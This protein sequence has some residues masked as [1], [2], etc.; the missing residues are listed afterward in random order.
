MKKAKFLLLTLLA[1]LGYSGAWAEYTVD[2][3]STISTS[4]SDFKVASNWKHIVDV[5]TYYDNNMSYQY[6]EDQGMEGSGTL[7]CN[8]Q[9]MYDWGQ[10][11]SGVVSYDLL[12]TPV[13]SGTVTIYAL[14]SSSAS[15][16]AKGFVEFWSLN[17]DGT[18]RDTKLGSQEWTSNS[19]AEWTAVT[20]T[21][22]TP[23]R[24]GIRGQ[25]VYLDNFSASS[26]EIVA[27]TSLTVA[28]VMNSTGQTGSTGT[29]PVFEQQPDGNMIA[30]LKVELLNSGD[31]DLIAGTTEGY[32]LTLGYASTSSS[33]PT[34]FTD[35]DVAITEDL[36]AG[37]TK[38]L[39]VSFNVPF[40]S[41]YKYYFIKENVTGTTTT[42]PRYATSVT[43]EPKFAFREAG[44]TSTSSLSG[45]VDF[46]M[47]STETTKNYE[48][49]NDGTAP[50]IVNSITAPEGFTMNVA[51]TDDTD[52]YLMHAGYDAD[53]AVWYAWTWYEGQDGTWVAE[54]DGKFSGLRDKVL[55]VRMNPTGA[56]SWDNK[57][58]Q[59]VDLDVENGSI[60]VIDGWGDE[61]LEGHWAIRVPAK[62]AKA[63]DITLPVTTTGAFSGNLEVKY[64]NASNTEVTYT[65][66]FTG[67]VL[68]EGVWFCDFN[69]SKTSSS[70]ASY[71]AGSVVESSTLYAAATGSYN[72]Y[73]QY[74][75]SY[76]RHDGNKFITPKLHFEAGETMTFDAIKLQTGSDYNITVYVC[77]DRMEWGSPFF[78]VSNNDLTETNTRVTQT[79]TAPM[80]GD[81]YFAFDIYGMGL[82]NIIG[83][84]LV[85]VDHDIYIKSVS[86]PHEDGGS[87]KSGTSQTKPTVT[88][89]PLTNETADAYTV[90]YIYGDNVVE[91]T[92]V[93]LTASATSTTNFSFSYTP[94]VENTTL[95]E[96]TK[97]VFEFTD[98]TTYET[99]TFN[100]KVTNEPVFH[101]V[102]TIP[103]SKWEP[104]DYTTPITFGKTNTEDSQ[105]FYIYNWG[106]APLHIH[107]ITLPEGFS[108][109]VTPP[110]DVAPFDENDLSASAQ[111][112]TITFSATEA[113][114]Y[115]G[116]MVITWP[117][118]TEVD[119][120]FSIALSGTKLD[121]NKWYANFGSESNQW[122]A[123]SVYQN[124]VSTTYVATGDYAITSSSTTNNMFITPKLTATAGEAL[125][126]DA[127]LYNSY[128]DDG[129]VKV[130]AAATRDELID[131]EVEKTPI[132]TTEGMTT[133]FQTFTVE[134]PEAGDFYLGFEISNRP[135]V[136]EIYGL[137]L[138]DVDYDLVMGDY[139]IPAEAMQNVPFT[140]TI[141][142]KNFGLE[143]LAPSAYNVFWVI[144]D[145][146]S[147]SQIAETAFGEKVIPMNH[148][149]TDAGTQLTVQLQFPKVGTYPVTIAITDESGEYLAAIEGVEVTFAEEEAQSEATADADGTSTYVPLNLMYYNSESVSLYTS[150][151]LSGSY[152]LTDGAKIKSITYK[153]YKTAAEHSS[154]LNVWYEW[155]DETTQQQPA[156]GLYDTEGMTQ[157]VTDE[158][159]VWETKGS[160]TAL[161]DFITLNFDEPLVYESGKALRIVV[162]SNSTAWKTVNFEKGTSATSGLAYYHYNDTQSTF[163]S[164]SWTSS[165]L[166]VLHM[167]LE[168]ATATISGTVIDESEAPVEGATVTLVS[169]DGDNVMYEGTTD[170]E[171]AYTINV[172]Q[173]GRTYNVT[174]SKEGYDDATEENVSFA[175]GDQIVNFTLTNIP[176][177]IEVTIKEGFDG[178]TIGSQYALDFSDSGLTVYKSTGTI[179]T[180]T[181]YVATEAMTEG[182]VPAEEGILVKGPAGTYQIPVV[183]DD[184]NEFFDD[185]LIVAAIDG[186]TP[187]QDDIESKSIYRYGKAGGKCGFQ[188]VTKQTQTVGA[189][190]AYLRLSDDLA[191]AAALLGVTFL[192]D[193]ET[194][195]IDTVSTDMLDQNAPMY[196]TAG[197]RVQKSYKGVVIQNGK[198]F[199]K[200]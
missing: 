69:G 168:S 127:K 23:Q 95:F 144:G 36:A 119:P 8:R 33:T 132:F 59:T 63:V 11:S 126:F 13:V 52:V 154:T 169:D 98:G 53:G 180:K 100:L 40:V 130:Y 163:E 147:D 166:P 2:F 148:K 22:D 183:E 14:P 79:M 87:I 161:E 137:T 21:V 92:P 196:N 146:T 5:D 182:I 81:F 93:A 77:S 88:V 34:F 178:T 16:S 55:F 141:N 49:Y 118:G 74:L 171:G 99:E 160:S 157:I 91:G 9:L 153:G 86:W 159:K 123:G 71:P 175:E 46:G 45:T 15:S 83:G 142:V 172:I 80:S 145:E 73:D 48:I 115:G 193:G 50:L 20:I 110:F 10:T 200:K 37:E 189:G 68:A 19:G 29:N 116:D 57:W 173:S 26:A 78:T 105:T 64:L 41:G 198:K 27:E 67:N 1:L 194:T 103:T 186:Y 197:Q 188:L 94:E 38:T 24:I 179:G 56:P 122:P 131:T 104:S 72:N 28:K 125:T 108:V 82:D 191:N 184:Y 35:A 32:T 120:T 117:M 187:T 51:E 61:K 25:Y 76:N 44:S 101:F 65:L 107:G 66:A 43:Y 4:S 164:N 128:W 158:T 111:A 75:R 70:T 102:K 114:E 12:V 62:S 140:A 113:G 17:S 109:D 143:D 185:N 195:G 3:N 174:V 151:V 47:I 106:S 167:Q 170:A 31:V 89:I 97:V 7:L 149:L 199:I 139:S 135:Y 177:F 129:Q 90:K 192:E 162:R 124:N 42:N 150:D 156:N 85:P 181:V 54:T 6:K 165:V 190:K 176:E 138:A 155:V 58:N 121:P 18:A 136:D 96:N 60:Y 84:T 30:N 133:D 39:D 152:K 134:M 112:V